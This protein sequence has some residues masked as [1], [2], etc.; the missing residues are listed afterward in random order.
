MTIGV[1]GST[2]EAELAAIKSMRGDV[3]PIGVEE[4]LRFF[5]FNGVRKE[6]PA[7]EYVSADPITA[8]CR[9]IK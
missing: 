6:A 7:L 3:P 9:T 4:R 1:G 2:A 5:V 8:G